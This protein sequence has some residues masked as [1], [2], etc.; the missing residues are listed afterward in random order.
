MS[1]LTRKHKCIF[2]EYNPCHSFDHL[3]ALKFIRRMK[4]VTP[5][6]QHERVTK[7]VKL[8][9]ITNSQRFMN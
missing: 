6:L 9:K 2:Q 8:R 1:L 7:R 5:V 3:F 4:N